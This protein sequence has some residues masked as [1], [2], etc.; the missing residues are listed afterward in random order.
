MP[1][2]LK[3][4][5]FKTRKEYRWAR[6]AAAKEQAAVVKP[7]VYLAMLMVVWIFTGSFLLGLAAAVA[8]PGLLFG[9]VVLFAR[10]RR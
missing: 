1:A 6:K 4:S 5:D 3:P 9:A 7:F 8:A 2:T 10:T